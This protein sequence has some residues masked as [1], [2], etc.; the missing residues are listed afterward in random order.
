MDARSDPYILAP[1]S[2]Q[3][4]GS[5]ENS[6]KLLYYQ[7][8]AARGGR[9]GVYIFICVFGGGGGWLFLFEIETHRKRTNQKQTQKHKQKEAETKS[10][11]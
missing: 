1:A 2:L 10:R 7:V 3:D 6:L 9:S 5:L 4:D 8:T 11:D